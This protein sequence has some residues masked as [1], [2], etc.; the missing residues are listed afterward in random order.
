MAVNKQQQL[1]QTKPRQ[2]GKGTR[3]KQTE[4]LAERSEREGERRDLERSQFERMSCFFD[5]QRSH[6]C[7]RVEILGFG[8]TALSFSLVGELE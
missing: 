6:A 7:T 5:A 8:K 3:Y 4:K 1:R 2:I